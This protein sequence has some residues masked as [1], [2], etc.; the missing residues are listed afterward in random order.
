MRLP[1]RVALLLGLIGC[2]GAAPPA[3]AQSTINPNI[4]AQNSP[5]QSAPVRAQFGAAINDINHLMNMTAGP[6]QPSPLMQFQ[7]WANTAGGSSVAVTLF[8]GSQSVT[9]GTL[10][11]SAHTWSTASG[12]VS[13]GTAGQLAYYAGTGN[14]VGPLNVGTGLFITGGSL[15][16]SNV[17]WSAITSTPTTLVGYGITNAR[18]RLVGN[19]GFF[20]DDINGS[21]ANACLSA[22]TGA[23]KSLNGVIA[24]IHAF[25]IGGF[26][27]TVSVA[28]PATSY[29][30]LACL[31]PW[32]GPGTVTFT[33]NTGSPL[34]VLINGGASAAVDVESGCA[35][36]MQG[37]SLQA[38][39]NV[40]QTILNGTI[41][42]IGPMDIGPSGT[43]LTQVYS[44]R[45]GY[46]EIDGVTS[47]HG[48]ASGGIFIQASH[49]GE[50]RVNG[51]NAIT[52]SANSTYSLGVLYNDGGRIIGTSSPSLSPGGFTIIANKWVLIHSG[53]IQWNGSTPPLSTD[54]PGTLLGSYALDSGSYNLWGATSGEISILAQAAAGTYNFNLPTTPGAVGACLASGGGGS[55]PMTWT[56]CATG[57]GV[58]QNNLNTQSGNYTILTT[59]CGVT[60][61]ET[62]TLKTITLPAA[63]GFSSVPNCVFSVYNANAT[64]GQILSGFPGAVAVSPT[65]ILWPLDTLTIQLVN[66]IW[67][68]LSYPGRHK[69]T[70][71]TT[72]FVDGTTVGASDSND[73]LAS[74]AAACKTIPGAVAYLQTWDG[75]AQTITLSVADSTYSNPVVFNGPIHGNPAV[76]LQGDL[77]TPSNAIISTTGAAAITLINGA[78]VSVGGF[79]VTTTTSGAGISVLNSSFATINGA[80]EYG[81]A[82]NA[83]INVGAGGV[84]TITANYTISGSAPFH[85]RAGGG[86][87]INAQSV[88]VTTSGTPAF[89]SGFASAINGGTLNA[90]GQ[91][92]SGTGATGLRF[93]VSQG[94]IVFTNQTNPNYFPGNAL[95]T[96]ASGGFI[97]SLQNATPVASGSC[98]VTTQ[99][100][101]IVGSFVASGACAGGTYILTFGAAAAHGWNCPA[102]DQTTAADFTKIN[103][104]ATSPTSATFTATTVNSDVVSFSCSPY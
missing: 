47:V 30:G 79:K 80:M 51:P 16:T 95:G 88:T 69:V 52:F 10:N 14:T 13:S 82:G 36:L 76:T 66:G 57:S 61:N 63:S 4:P 49:G 43:S 56:T 28:A 40:S 81:A 38:N 73:C 74:G 94:G 24:K 26:G 32:V 15:V 104:T 54:I 37:F 97:D 29:A 39:F 42:Y 92:Y 67:S 33:G 100:G 103:Q 46:T 78:T 25:D 44:S 48:G 96:V 68:I 6:T 2:L 8:D 85:Y 70:A 99:L 7:F 102:S 18:P 9:I 5:L 34:S 21:D 60:I 12:N 65:N 64:R 58:Q 19:T 72:L 35:I 11:T 84:A 77:A 98:A 75:N 27:V 45:Q 3:E 1:P 23:C 22:T 53:E 20:V 91:T 101:N 31:Q 83:Q 55:N 59:D 71:A 89:V 41:I 90:F 50:V 62:G 93:S 17:P 86:G 87:T